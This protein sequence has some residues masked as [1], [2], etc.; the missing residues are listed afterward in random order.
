MVPTDTGF[1]RG[2]VGLE[3][4]VAVEDYD[5]RHIE[6]RLARAAPSRSTLV[7]APCTVVYKCGRLESQ[8]RGQSPADEPKTAVETTEHSETHG[9]A[10]PYE[11]RSSHLVGGLSSFRKSLY[12]IFNAD[13]RASRKGRGGRKGINLNPAVASHRR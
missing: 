6:M 2:W 3:E 5:R 12:L 9:K 11:D 13:G 1:V 4:P 8:R 7:P 10:T